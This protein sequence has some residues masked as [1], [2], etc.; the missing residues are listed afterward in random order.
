M[1][2]MVKTQTTQES[3]RMRSVRACYPA[4]RDDVGCIRVQRVLPAVLDQIDPFVSFAHYG[5][6]NYT[7]RAGLYAFG[8]KPYRGFEEALVVLSGEMNYRDDTGNSGTVRPGGVKWVSAGGG[9]VQQEEVSEEFVRTA[10]RFELLRLW[11]NLP[12]AVKKGESVSRILQR[13]ELLCFDLHDGN[14]V[15]DLIAGNLGRRRGPVRSAI[16]LTLFMLRMGAGK[17]VRVPAPRGYTACV[18]LLRGSISVSDTLVRP[19][20]F[21]RLADDGDGFEIVSFERS[22]M[23]VATAPPLNEPLVAFGPFVMNTQTEVDQAVSDYQL[24]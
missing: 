23:M 3:R 12:A 11:V 18:Y 15:I 13:N 7:S 8:T 20:H 6:Q 16:D 14:V 5:P 9:I 10:G 22:V 1:P 4:L 19:Y 2:S 24:M 21:V 17:V